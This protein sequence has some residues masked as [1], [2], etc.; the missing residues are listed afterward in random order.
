MYVPGRNPGDV[1]GKEDGPFD[2][3]VSRS[4]EGP[5]EAEPSVPCV[6]MLSRTR[7]DIPGS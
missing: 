5:E 7:G 2:G 1:T 3:G 4:H 6:R